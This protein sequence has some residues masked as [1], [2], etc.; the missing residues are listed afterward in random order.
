MP[1]AAAAQPP[2]LFPCLV[3]LVPPEPT[4]HFP[5]WDWR[6]EWASQERALTWPRRLQHDSICAGMD[7][8]GYSTSFQEEGP[9]VGIDLRLQSSHVGL[10]WFPFGGNFR[11]G[12]Q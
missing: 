2:L 5:G 11:V 10:D 4:G 7:F 1:R 9:N 6:R 3:L 12:P 8:F